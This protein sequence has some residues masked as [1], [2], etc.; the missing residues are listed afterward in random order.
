M[1]NPKNSRNSG[2]KTLSYLYSVY[3]PSMVLSQWSTYSS[4]SDT[5]GQGVKTRTRTCDQGDC[6]GE[7][8]FENAVCN[9]GGCK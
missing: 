8:L 1:I 7:D 9:E 6:T 3:T 2:S 5:C 4:C